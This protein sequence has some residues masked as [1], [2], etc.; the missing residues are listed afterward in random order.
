M[1]RSRPIGKQSWE[2]IRGVSPEEEKEG[3]E[4]KYLR[5]RGVFKAGVK[6]RGVI[7]CPRA[8]L[9]NY[10]SDIHQTFCACYLSS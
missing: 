9:R 8:Y 2:S 3:Y 1:L 6:E 4:R 10:M 5:K 7:V